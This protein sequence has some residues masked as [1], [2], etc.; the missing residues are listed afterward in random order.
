MKRILL[1]LLPLVLVQMP[2][3]A[4]DQPQGIHYQA[5]AR[6]LDG[7]LLKNQDIAL[8][9]VLYFMTD[10]S[11]PRTEA[12]SEYHRVRTDQLGLF[13]VNIGYGDPVQGEYRSVP[14]STQ[15]I[16]VEVGIDA[17]GL[18]NF[19]AIS[20]SPLMSVPY[21]LHALTAGSLTDVGSR[22]PGGSNSNNWHTFGNAN[23]DP[24]ED[25]L[26]TSDSADLSI[27]TDYQER[28]RISATGEIAITSDLSIGNDL[29]VGNDVTIGN[30][31]EVDGMTLLHD[32]L[33]L[34]KS[35]TGFI[36][37]FQNDDTGTGDGILI[38]L[39]RIATKNNP[40]A[41]SA[42]V[43]AKQYLG[44]T[45][46]NDYENL[47]SLISGEIDS[48]DTD[49]L[50]GL[51]IPDN[52]DQF[53]IDLLSSGCLLVED[54]L[55]PLLE[56]GVNTAI[57]EAV[58]FIAAPINDVIDI[59][60]DA[61]G[62]VGWTGA[63]DNNDRIPTDVGDISVAGLADGLCDAVGLSDV[64]P[65]EPL[66]L[67]GW[68][69]ETDPL[70]KENAFIEFA[71][72]SGW[73]MGAITAQSVDEWAKSLLDPV[74]LFNMYATFRKL[75]KAGIPAELKK[76]SKEI[77]KKYVAVGVS[78]S[79]GNGDYAEWLER[80][81]H[82]E[83]IESGDVVGVHAGRITKNL[84]GCEQVM[85]VS[86]KPIVLG[87]IPEEGKQH[88]GNNVAFMGQIPVKVLG[89]V[90]SGDY[91]VGSGNVLGYAVAVHPEDMTLEDFKNTVGRSWEDADI[92]GP[93]MVNT[94]IGMHNGDYLN[95]LR[96]YDERMNSAE[97][98]LQAIESSLE[99][100]TR[101]YSR[102]SQ[103]K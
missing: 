32:D 40:T 4:Q 10:E 57:Q 92:E 16:W 1:L 15:N 84:E 58:S 55:L 26:G 63:I 53:A 43:A 71:D 75:D 19:T 27:I 41:Q 60:D 80:L 28:L 35:D 37:T 24:S 99:N 45:N 21:A 102:A 22:G 87:N 74:F 9:F 6:N 79:S 100:L 88:A 65:F 77:A 94:V 46:S 11:Q 38:Q 34:T 5:A 48:L 20:N 89:P 12:Y 76:Q 86:A 47:A 17:E 70:V 14:W 81:D 23:T 67:G 83:H 64:F 96:R 66:N 7:T 42:H 61:L 39:G 30:N 72:S 50:A 68:E 103:D 90:L 91:L 78:Y 51:A 36:A 82:E 97:A 52:I 49:F 73:K 18:G 3:M 25:F 59:V 29:D 54:V 98:R 44:T 33:N 56:L 13:N 8:E 69:L 62:S 95:V 85:A 31:L 93:H 2:T 101:S